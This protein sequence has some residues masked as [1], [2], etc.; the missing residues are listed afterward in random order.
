MKHDIGFRG[1][2]RIGAGSLLIICLRALD[3]S[4]FAEVDA[5]AWVQEWQIDRGRLFRHTYR[6]PRFGALL[7]CGLCRG[8]GTTGGHEQCSLCDGT[9]RIDRLQV[10]G[11]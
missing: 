11:A 9:G 3:V 2:P 1:G 5:F 8:E 10:G 7:R 4:I 6:D